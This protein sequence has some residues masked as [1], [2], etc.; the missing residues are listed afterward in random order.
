[1]AII[2]AAAGQDFTISCQFIIWVDDEPGSWGYDGETGAPVEAD[3]NGEW[4]R[5][6]NGVGWLEGSRWLMPGNGIAKGKSLLTDLGT[7]ITTQTTDDN[8][9]SVVW[10]P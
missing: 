7:S 4:I 5:R 1:M 3:A 10:S 6:A 2:G 9:F 8:A